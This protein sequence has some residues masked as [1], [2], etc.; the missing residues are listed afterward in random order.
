MLGDS[1]GVRDTSLICVFRGVG[2]GDLA[3]T[4]TSDCGTV[5]LLRI[6]GTGE[7]RCEF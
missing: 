7:F 5:I 2:I 4:I 6:A 3:G 1:V